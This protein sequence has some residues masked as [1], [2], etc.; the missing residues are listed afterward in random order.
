[1]LL[2]LDI[3]Q[4]KLKQQAATAPPEIDI[5]DTLL[6]AST[7]GDEAIS[8]LEKQLQLKLP[9]SFRQF[10]QTYDLGRF[11]IGTVSFGTNG[12][13]L[14]FLVEQNL[15][16]IAIKWWGTDTKRPTQYLL[17]GGSDGHILLLNI[18]TGQVYGYLRTNWWHT[19]SIIARNLECF[20]RAAATIY[21]QRRL[22]SD[23]EKFAQAIV[24]VVDGIDEVQFWR[25]LV[26]GAT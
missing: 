4:S 18:V 8:I 16:D 22:V 15:D 20:I 5:S 17:I 21:F 9:I 19:A 13:Y 2:E 26:L 7:L 10:L 24:E 6:L 25:D 14:R 11:S 3:I 23:K 12:D 1:M